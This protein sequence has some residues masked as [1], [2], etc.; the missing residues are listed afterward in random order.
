MRFLGNRSSG[1]MGVAL[2]D[3]ARRRGAEVT[4]LLCNAAVRPAGG[5]VVETPTAADLEREARARAPQADV[6]LMAAAVADYRPRE[7]AEGK[8]TR[9]GDW[10]LELEP[11]AD[12]LAGLGAARR[13]GQ[14]LVGFAAETGDGLARAAERE[15]KGVDLVVLNDV[16]RADI[17]F[18]VAENEVALVERRRRRAPSEGL[19]DDRRRGHPRPGGATALVERA[20]AVG[21]AFVAGAHAR[22]APPVASVGLG[23]KPPVSGRS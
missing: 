4:T 9:S 12:I 21:G 6:V 13:P 7:V 10:T 5:E 20:S 15:R 11:T 17:G 16:S 1:R 2:A 14:V 23:A 18:E 8:R 22:A 19:E 3:E